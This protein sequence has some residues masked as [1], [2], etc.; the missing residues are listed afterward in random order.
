MADNKQ[1]IYAKEAYN[2][3]CRS[4]DNIGWKYQR[5]DDEMKIMFGV[6]G[7][8]LPMTFLA[9]IDA[10]RQLIRL[11]SL[12]PFKMN[13]DKIVEGAVAVCAINYLLADGSFDFDIEEG[14]ILFRLTSSFRNSLLGEDAFKYIVGVACHTIDIY[15]DKLLDLNEG[16]IS[17]G[18]FINLIAQ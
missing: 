12:L 3:L 9:I 5:M 15:N 18:D 6:N 13:R 8:D 1:L 10:D 4:L 16:R 14:N 2:G 7:D 17:M 11:I